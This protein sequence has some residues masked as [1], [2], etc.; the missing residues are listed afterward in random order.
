MVLL[1]PSTLVIPHT[2]TINSTQTGNPKP[3]HC[4]DQMDADLHLGMAKNIAMSDSRQTLQA[5]FISP[6]LAQSAS[7]CIWHSSTLLPAFAL[8]TLPDLPRKSHL[9]SRLKPVT[10]NRYE[11]ALLADL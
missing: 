9:A 2:S 4:S 7:L 10:E 11:D 8:W 3:L 1:G 5:P 6:H